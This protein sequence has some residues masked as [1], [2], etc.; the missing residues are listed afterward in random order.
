VGDFNLF[1]PTIRRKRKKKESLTR[2]EKTSRPAHASSDERK[3][4]GKGLILKIVKDH[5]G[6]KSRISRHKQ[7]R[8]TLKKQEMPPYSSQ[9]IQKE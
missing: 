9:L 4:E 1:V 7:I 5:Q 3:Q 2:T 6:G 8:N